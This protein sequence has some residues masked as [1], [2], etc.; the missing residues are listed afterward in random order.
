MRIWCKC[1]KKIHPDKKIRKSLFINIENSDYSYSEVY[2]GAKGI[3]N[4]YSQDLVLVM[5]YSVRDGIL[6]NIKKKH[7]YRVLFDYVD[8]AYYINDDS[9]KTY[10]HLVELLSVLKKQVVN[11]YMD[12]Y[13]KLESIM[14]EFITNY[15]NL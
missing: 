8:G 7:P 1:I 2:L 3:L 12:I 6:V 10:D 13:E 5:S 4:I 9:N 15:C 11:H 14:F